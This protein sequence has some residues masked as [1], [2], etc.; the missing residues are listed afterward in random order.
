MNVFFEFHKIVQDL[1]KEAIIDHALVAESK[2]SGTVRVATKEDLI[3]L[4]SIRN[5]PMDQAD[6]ETLKDENEDP[7]D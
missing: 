4:K 2:E 3:W 5:S 1:Q 6:I 7:A